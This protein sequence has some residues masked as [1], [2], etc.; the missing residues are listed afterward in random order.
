MY[1]VTIH[2]EETIA[3]EDAMNLEDAIARAK[4]MFDPTANEP[5]VIDAWDDND[6]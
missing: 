5:E 3:V 4:S 6:D 1:Y 2:V